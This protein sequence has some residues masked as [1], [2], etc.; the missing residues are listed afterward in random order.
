MRNTNWQYN[1]LVLT[2]I[3][4]HKTRPKPIISNQQKEKEQHP[5]QVQKM[6]R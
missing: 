3:K 1:I 4:T 6:A 2:S 5:P